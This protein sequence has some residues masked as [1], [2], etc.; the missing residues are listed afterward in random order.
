MSTPARLGTLV[1]GTRYVD[2]AT[3]SV[4]YCLDLL[5]LD[6]DA[7]EPLRIPL[8]FLAHGFALHPAR[9]E[10][11]LLEKRGP[12]AVYVDLARREV[13][14]PIAPLPGHHF[15]GHGAFSRDAGALFA[16]ETELASNEGVISVRDPSSFAVVDT[17]PTFGKAPHDC[18]LIEDG[19]TLAVTNGGGPT[20]AGATPCV[21]FVDVASRRL[22]EKLEVSD[23]RINAGHVAVTKDR[24]FVLASAPRDGL[25]EAALGGVSVRRKGGPLLYATQ[26]AA[27]TGRMIGESLSVCIHEGTRTALVTH[28][29]GGLITFWNLDTGALFAAFD[30]P[31]AR[32]VTL[33][34]DER[35]FAVSYGLSAGLLLIETA[36]LRPVLE[37]DPGARRFSGSH[38]YAWSA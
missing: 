36:P 9:P 17:F 13:L 19:R 6:A 15:Y 27:A 3:Q 31:H 1:G 26:P 24:A 5:D 10:A 34:L 35:Y 4:R 28:P 2:P 20:G 33:T 8:G 7:A 11:V 16:V 22:L 14:R 29:Y 37:R 32:G 25:P 12:G 23:P 18:L 30:L 21:S 38:V